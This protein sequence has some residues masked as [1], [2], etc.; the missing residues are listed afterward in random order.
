MVYDNLNVGILDEKRLK[1]KKL[2]SS[3]VNLVVNKNSSKKQET[4]DNPIFLKYNDQKSFIG[5]WWRSVVSGVKFSFGLSNKE[6]RELKRN[7]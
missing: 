6:Q 2:V 4:K 5:Y 3:L 1:E 7:N